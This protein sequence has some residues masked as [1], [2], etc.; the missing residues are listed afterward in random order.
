M[1][2]DPASADLTARARI[3]DSA[4]LLFG[5]DGYLA[6]SV[7]DVA[8]HAGVSAGLVIHHFG[9]KDDLRRECDTYVVHMIA[10]KAELETRPSASVLQELMA[11][12]DA[13]GPAIDYLARMLVDDSPEAARLFDLLFEETREVYLEGVEAGTMNASSDDD[14]LAM[15]L[16]AGGLGPLLLRRHITRLFGVDYLSPEFLNRLM[17]PTVELYTNGLYADDTMLTAARQLA[18]DPR[19]EDSRP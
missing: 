12:V 15:L 19:R 7:R 10:E 17:L 5:R 16:L 13:F 3:R 1:T 8:S 6:T 11:D 2:P 14:L 9:S 4:L 18:T